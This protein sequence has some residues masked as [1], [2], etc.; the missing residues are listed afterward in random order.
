ML[1]LELFKTLIQNRQ[2]LI[3][4]LMIM[5]T[6]GV[7]KIGKEHATIPHEKE[8]SQEIITLHELNEKNKELKK[9]QATCEVEKD[10][11][12]TLR[13]FDSCDSRIKKALNDAEA[14]ACED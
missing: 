13:C 7:Y 1:S 3:C 14:W 8:C 10:S 11:K 4:V 5:L 2:A 6:A 9:D 12:K